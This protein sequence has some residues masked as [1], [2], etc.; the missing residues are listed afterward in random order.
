MLWDYQD[1]ETGPE[2]TH[3]GKEKDQGVEKAHQIR[4][5]TISSQSSNYSANHRQ[6][7][8]DFVH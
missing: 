5:L 4:K 8:F 6:V 7:R 2:I 3:P 1:I